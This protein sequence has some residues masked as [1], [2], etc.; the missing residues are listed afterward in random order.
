LA[1]VILAQ[2]IVTQAFWLASCLDLCAFRGEGAP[3]LPANIGP[4]ALQT[5]G[6]I[7]F[8]QPSG[9]DDEVEAVLK[10]PGGPGE[11]CDKQVIPFR[12]TRKAGVAVV[13]ICTVAVMMAT[14]VVQTTHEPLSVRPGAVV[15]LDGCIDIVK[16]GL[17]ELRTSNANDD[18]YEVATQIKSF[19]DDYTFD[20]YKDDF[21]RQEGKTDSHTFGFGGGYHESANFNLAQAFGVGAHASY[22]GTGGG[23]QVDH[24]KEQGVGESMGVDG[25][26]SWEDAHTELTRNQFEK[27]KKKILSTKRL[28]SNSQQSNG[29]SSADAEYVKKILDPQVSQMYDSCVEF[30]NPHLHASQEAT[31]D[32][33]QVT[34]NLEF[35]NGEGPAMQVPAMVTGVMVEPQNDGNCRI[36][37]PQGEVENLPIELT[38]GLFVNV[39]CT[40]QS[41]NTPGLSVSVITNVAKAYKAYFADTA[42]STT[43]DDMRSELHHIKIALEAMQEA[44]KNRTKE[45]KIRAKEAKIRAGCCSMRNYS[46]CI[47]TQV[48]EFPCG[49]SCCVCGCVHNEYSVHGL[50]IAN[51]CKTCQCNPTCHNPEC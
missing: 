21:S 47:T 50:C 16:A 4:S 33:K 18:S 37:G 11:H 31:P 9:F 6:R 26:L 8:M 2:A 34:V 36:F 48:W 40:R 42:P 13:F 5:T 10:M 1:Q 32:G 35:A 39:I 27:A 29:Q 43:A 45:A 20:Q 23:V 46:I 28:M 38:Q 3:K 44:A 49:T 22:L 19:S 30:R 12:R 7:D 24:S 41:G 14:A 17:D 15:T 25:H 51:G